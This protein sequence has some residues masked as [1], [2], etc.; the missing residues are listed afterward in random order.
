[1][2]A[3]GRARPHAAR[4]GAG[5]GRAPRRRGGRA[6]PE[7]P[8]P[9]IITERDILRRRSGAGQDP[10][11]EH[12]ADHLTT[13]LVFA[14]P[15]WSLEQ[16]RRGDGARRLPPPGR[17]RRAASSPASSRARHR[18]L[19]DGRRRRLRRAAARQR[20]RLTSRARRRCS[21]RHSPAEQAARARVRRANG[22]RRGEDRPGSVR[23]WCSA[24]AARCRA[25][26]T[27]STSTS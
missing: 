15:D 12:V 24:G 25:A 7:R 16:A 19:L 20:A 9:G 6:R 18:A 2:V 17:H 4:G 21:H 23:E 8:G 13:D 11:A 26:S 1:M 14:A 10:D 22:V 3:D 27:R 5:D